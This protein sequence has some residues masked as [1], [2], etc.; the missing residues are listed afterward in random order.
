MFSD[1]PE[2]DATPS[3]SHVKTTKP[4][5]KKTTAAANKKKKNAPVAKHNGVS[6]NEKSNHNE[7]K[8]YRGPCIQ[9]KNNKTIILN[10]PNDDDDQEKNPNKS[11]VSCCFL[12]T[13][14]YIHKISVLSG[15][16]QKV[17]TQ[18]C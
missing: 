7:N 18:S 9:I 4:K 1:M 15:D 16:I 8:G 17:R 14:L 12:T 3:T 2:K 5:A 6:H 11:R 10:F 13:F